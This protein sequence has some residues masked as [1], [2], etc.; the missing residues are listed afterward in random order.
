MAII[1]LDSAAKH[2][3]NRADAINAIAH[4]TGHKAGFNAPRDGDTRP[5]LAI[6]PSLSGREIEVM[7]Q[8]DDP[9]LVIFHCMEARDH[10]KNQATDR[11]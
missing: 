10:I 2:G 11:R 1:F 3:F 5:D 7:Y 6:G 9:D 8:V 4:R